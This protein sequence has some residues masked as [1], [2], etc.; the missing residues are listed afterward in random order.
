LYFNRA[1]CLQLCIILSLASQRTIYGPD[2]V[3]SGYPAVPLL[4]WQSLLRATSSTE[5]VASGYVPMCHG[6]RR[7][8]TVWPVKHYLAS[9]DI[10]VNQSNEPVARGCT[11]SEPVKELRGRH[12]LQRYSSSG[13]A[14]F[15]IPCGEVSLAGSIPC[16][17]S[18]VGACYAAARVARVSLAATLRNAFRHLGR[19]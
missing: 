10:R 7:G 1:W 9:R 5:K 8:P 15:S 4:G 2:D 14:F 6:G 18:R 13:G 17:W 16:G 3:G 11:E 12:H 19:I